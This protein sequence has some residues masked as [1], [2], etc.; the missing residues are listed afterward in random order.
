MST[1]LAELSLAVGRP[2]S[3]SDL[4]ILRNVGNLSSEALVP[5]SVET[6]GL[7]AILVARYGRASHYVKLRSPGDVNAQREAIVLEALHN[8]AS[9]AHLVPRSQGFVLPNVSALILSVV[10]GPSFGRRIAEKPLDAAVSDA[11]TCLAERRRLLDG[12]IST[13]TIDPP[14]TTFNPRESLEPSLRVLDE[15]WVDSETIAF[16]RTTMPEVMRAAPQHGDFTPA[17][18]IWSRTGPVFLDFEY[19]GLIHSPLYDTWHFIR[20]IRQHRTERFAWLGTAD[21]RSRQD[22]AWRTLLD[23]EAAKLGLTESEILAALLWYLAHFSARFVSRGN[24]EDY[25]RPYLEDLRAA[26]EHSSTRR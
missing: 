17:N 15:G 23:E 20:N 26:V 9:W 16:I 4:V 22:A 21:P 24:P 11:R 14:P 7:H 3:W 8:G 5:D 10:E 2:I 25:Y 19:F 1:L 6:R 18:I 13:G 12:A